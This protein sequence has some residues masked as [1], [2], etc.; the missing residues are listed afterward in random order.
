MNW[1]FD[2][3][4]TIY[5]TNNVN[6]SSIKTDYYLRCL[7]NIKIKLKILKYF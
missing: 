4:N 2:L 1:V 7:L 5:N 3:D 6:Y